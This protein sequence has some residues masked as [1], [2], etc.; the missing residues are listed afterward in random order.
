MALNARGNID[1]KLAHELRNWGHFK[2]VYDS[3]QAWLNPTQAGEAE[4]ELSPQT[5][6]QVSLRL[7]DPLMLTLCMVFFKK[8]VVGKSKEN[9]GWQTVR[10]CSMFWPES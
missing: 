3:A 1:P 4:Q 9:K 2:A 8:V 5:Q 6:F 7:N 10:L